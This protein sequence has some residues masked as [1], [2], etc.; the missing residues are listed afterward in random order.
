MN[1]LLA[2]Q[3][4]FGKSFH[5]Q[6]FIEANLPDYDRV[7]ILDPKDEY[8]GLVEAHSQV[9]RYIV[10]PGEVS[11]PPEFWKALLAGSEAIQLPQYDLTTERWRE[12]CGT[13]VHA[14]R[15]FDGS[16]LVC[17]D[18]AHEVAPQE[19][20]FPEPIKLLA[21]KGRG[22]GASSL[23]ITQ[24]LQELHKT[25]VSQCTGRLLGGFEEEND[26]GKIRS[27]VSYP[28]DVHNPQLSRIPNLPEE[29]HHP[30]EGPI[31]VQKYTDDEGNTVGSE[32]IYSDDS[33]V[34]ERRDTR[35]LQMVAPHHGAQ[36]KGLRDPDYG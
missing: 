15:K 25:V 3:T 6:A 11:Y 29:L 9:K 4:G 19:G 26:L 32:W 1:L 28:A 18:E 14:A 13:I 10:G 24:R 21:T 20:D 34:R 23:W 31:P 8:T 22:E 2:A 27:T 17:L 5:G 16:V 7:L 36:G 30:E 12:V 33:G 35:N